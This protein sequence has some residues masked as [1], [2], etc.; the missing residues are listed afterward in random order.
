MG[1]VGVRYIIK[2]THRFFFL[3]EKK[4]AWFDFQILQALANMVAFFQ[5]VFEES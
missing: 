1:V 5:V 4:S 2:F 3:T